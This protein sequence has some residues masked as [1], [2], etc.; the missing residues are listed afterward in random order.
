ML[1]LMLLLACG[2]KDAAPPVETTVIGGPTDTGWPE[3]TGDEETGTDL[4]G[5]GWTVE[6]GD[7]DDDNI[8]VNPARDED[9]TDGIDN[10]CDGRQDEDFAGL[11]VIQVWYD[12]NP[13]LIH[14]VDTLG[15]IERTVTLDDPEVLPY[16]MTW[17][18]DG[19][20]A[21]MDLGTFAVLTVDDDGTTAVLAEFIDE[22]KAEEITG[23]YGMATHPDGYYLIACGNALYAIEPGTGSKTVLASWDIEQELYPYDIAVDIQTGDV[24]LFGYYGGFATFDGAFNLHIPGALNGPGDKSIF[25]GERGDDGSWYAGAFT[26]NGFEVLKLDDASYTWSSQLVFDQQWDPTF[27]T[28][29]GDSGDYYLSANAAS[30]PTVWRVSASSGDQTLFYESEAIGS[31]NVTSVWDI[32]TRY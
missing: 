10:D 31:T 6:E 2:D 3:D 9:P 13:S 20:Y 21:V 15:N 16:F 22:L 17:G 11:A 25:S 28:I 32:F 23:F 5:D 14:H 30:Y 18:V 4:D 19:G 29:D 24:G 1:S 8:Y 12:E 26:A 27:F 7:C